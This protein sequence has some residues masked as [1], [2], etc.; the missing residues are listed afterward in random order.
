MTGVDGVGMALD[1]ADTLVVN[2]REYP[3]FVIPRDGH[4]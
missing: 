4:E 3:Y 1:D 2:E